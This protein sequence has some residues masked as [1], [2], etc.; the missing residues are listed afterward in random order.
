[1]IDTLHARLVVLMQNSGSGAG[2]IQWG[3]ASPT[4]PQP[5]SPWYREIPEPVPGAPNSGGPVF[6][7]VL[8]DVAESKIEPNFEGSD[9]EVYEVTVKVYCG[10]VNSPFAPPMVGL[11][12][13]PYQLKKNSI[14]A[15]LDSFSIQCD[16]L[17][18]D[19][20]TFY[21]HHWQRESYEILKEEIRDPT[22][23]RV[24]VGMAKYTAGVGYQIN[25]P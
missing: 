25:T 20:G 6:P 7:Y 1:V 12:T 16:R 17:N 5:G 22:G 8:F 3:S 4:Q 11:V 13:S 14:I 23:G 15:Y 21:M 19:V 18:G 24:W 9:I 10:S 2:L